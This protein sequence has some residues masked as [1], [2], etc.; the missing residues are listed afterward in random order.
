M[1]LTVDKDY[2]TQPNTHPPAFAQSVTPQTAGAVVYAPST[3]GLIFDQSGTVS[4]R[5]AG[6][7]NAV[8]AAIVGV[9]A[10]ISMAANGVLTSTT[11]GKFNSLLVNDVVV[12]SGFA[13][14][15]NNGTFRIA[16]KTSG[17]S[18]TLKFP[19]DANTLATVAETPA[20]ATATVQG[21]RT[22]VQTT[23]TVTVLA[24]AFYPLCVDEW[25]TGGAGVTSGT[26]FW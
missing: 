18:L 17:T 12:V 10:D 4:L 3:R 13:N 26:I 20:G 11:G 24:G 8:P 1:T 22:S 19:G 5:M 15:N 2:K 14:P 6:V 7:K 25:I 16:V 21:P 9:S 23:V